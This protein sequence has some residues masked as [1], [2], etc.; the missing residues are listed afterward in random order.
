MN[1]FLA[2]M[3]L[4]SLNSPADL[5]MLDLDM[6]PD[7]RVTLNSP[8]TGGAPATFYILTEDGNTLTDESG[9]KLIIE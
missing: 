5:A 4:A 8:G 2:L 3:L 6:E 1:T 7:I 9:N